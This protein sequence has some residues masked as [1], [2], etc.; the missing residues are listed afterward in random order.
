MTDFSEHDQVDYSFLFPKN[1]ESYQYFIKKVDPVTYF[2]DTS[3]KS[4][5]RHPLAHPG[6]SLIMLLCLCGPI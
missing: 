4:Q 2:T 6:H 3:F 1:S 5:T